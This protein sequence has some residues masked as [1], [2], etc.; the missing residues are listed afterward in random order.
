MNE[1]TAKFIKYADIRYISSKKPINK[2]QVTR[3]RGLPILIT[4][5]LLFAVA[6]LLI[7][8]PMFPGNVFCTLIGG[9]IS[10]YSEYLSAIFNGVFYS[11]ILWLIFV[12]ISKRLLEEK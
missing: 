7:P 3:M 5:F 1:W 11:V 12:L 6:S 2:A 9:A 8:T 10:E 4:F